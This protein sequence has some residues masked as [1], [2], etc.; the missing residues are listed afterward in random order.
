MTI[1]G[2]DPGSRRIGYGLVRRDG[3]KLTYLAAGIL[4]IRSV[5]D[6]DALM[7]TK[8]GIT[9]LIEAWR[10]ACLSIERLYFT[11]NRTTGIQVAQAR[12]V[13]L[14]ACAEEGLAIR[15]FTPNE[16]KL[17]LTGFGGADKKSVA[18]MVRLI[19]EQP[20]LAL[21]DDAMDALGMAIVGADQFASETNARVQ[22][23]A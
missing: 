18:K 4:P 1:L 5:T 12:G 20:S 13:V 6:P 8:R 7:E 10:P 16:I 2:I 3:K 22:P 14:A 21:I 17:K 11:K 23:K 19:L 15:E 9:A